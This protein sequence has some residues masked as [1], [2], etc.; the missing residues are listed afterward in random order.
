MRQRQNELPNNMKV[1]I[2]FLLPIYRY[3][4]HV[5]STAEIN[6]H[7]MILKLKLR[8]LGE[9]SRIYFANIVEPY[10]VSIGHHVYINKNCDIITTGSTVEIGNYVMV[11]PNV[12]FIA[13]NHDT[14]DWKK[15]MLFSEKY[16]HGNIK[17]LD[18]VWIGANATILAGV[19][20]NKGAVVG[21]GAVVTKDVPPYAIVA[22]VPAS[23]IKNRIPEELIPKAQKINF[24]SFEHKSIDW[25]T[26]GVGKK[27]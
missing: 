21:A 24:K 1:I 23:K 10:N 15:P 5:I 4:Y 17:V 27:A 25:R 26:W 12:T 3:F 19:T 13:Q 20:I 16:K 22:G 18:D 11:G 14:S 9:H 8:T 2:Y 6:L 7:T